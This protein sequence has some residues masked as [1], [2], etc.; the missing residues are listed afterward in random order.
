[1]TKKQATGTLD[2][3]R[4]STLFVVGFTL[5]LVVVVQYGDMLYKINWA[6]VALVF[7]LSLGSFILYR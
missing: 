5:S 6:I 1:V 2:A 3:I 7:V 4:V